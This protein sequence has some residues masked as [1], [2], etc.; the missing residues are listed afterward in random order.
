MKDI[1]LSTFS[2]STLSMIAPSTDPEA[3]PGSHS[4]MSYCITNSSVTSHDI[5]E[6]AEP[7][8]AAM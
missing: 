6:Q 4:D 8:E 5:A 3:P 2:E 1:G 7:S